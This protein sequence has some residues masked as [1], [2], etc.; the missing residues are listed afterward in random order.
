MAF[1]MACKQLIDAGRAA[2]LAA[3]SEHSSAGG[4]RRALLVN[5]IDA[6]VTG[7]CTALLW[8]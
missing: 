5:Y 1:G 6:S 8:S 4:P 2:A 3:H 7:E